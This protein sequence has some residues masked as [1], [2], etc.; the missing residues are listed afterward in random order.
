MNVLNYNPVTLNFALKKA[1][2]VFPVPGL[3]N[4]NMKAYRG[5][6]D[7]LHAILHLSTTWR[8][9]SCSGRFTSNKT[10]LG[11][12]GQQARLTPGTVRTSQLLAVA[13]IQPAA[14]HLTE[15]PLFGTSVYLLLTTT[16][17]ETN[18]LVSNA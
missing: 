16:K 13:E 11:T 17:Q 18:S 3:A 7:K 4:Y 10:P 2:H 5:R 1:D 15:V 6:K 12:V 14:I 9:A 8:R